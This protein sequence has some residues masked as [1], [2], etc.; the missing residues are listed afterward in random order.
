MNSFT[1]RF[2]AVVILLLLLAPYALSSSGDGDIPEM[3]P[4][5]G[6]VVVPT[7]T[8]EQDAGVSAPDMIDV[9][10]NALNALSALALF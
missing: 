5:S 6:G 7:M 3:K 4:G 2:L 9:I 1:K 10:V 8:A